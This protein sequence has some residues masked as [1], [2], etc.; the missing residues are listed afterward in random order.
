VFTV[1]YRPQ[2]VPDS[3]AP[4]RPAYSAVP[5]SPAIPAPAVPATGKK[6]Y[7]GMLDGFETEDYAFYLGEKCLYDSA[8][9]GATVV[10]Y[11]G[12]VL[13]LPGCVTPV[14]AIGARWIP[15]LDPVLVRLHLPERSEI[16]AGGASPS[17]DRI[18]MVCFNG[19]EK[20]VELPEWK[21]A[22]ASARFREFGNFQLLY[23]SIPPVITPIGPLEGADLSHTARIAIRVSDNLGALRRFRAELDGQWL[24]FTNDKALAYI[25]KFDEHCPPGPHMLKVTVEDVAGNR[26][27]K[28]YHFNR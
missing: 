10:G 3:V 4:M 16:A 24:C 2:E 18:V 19:G 6:F 8:I 17:T 13:S 28:E 22:W 26:T 1:Q 11:P 12:S 14:Y 27:E 21:G 23:D 5:A 20:D 9:I 7:P 15:L 25:Y